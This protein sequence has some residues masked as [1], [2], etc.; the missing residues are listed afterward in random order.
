MIPD[1]FASGLTGV[2]QA[3]AGLKA[4]AAE[5]FTVTDSGGQALIDAMNDLHDEITDAISHSDVLGQE[6]PLGQTPAAQVY[7]PFLATIA[8]DPHQGMIP[9]LR[10][11]LKDL[12][13][14]RDSIQK[15]ME[16]YKGTDQ[17]SKQGLNKAGGTTYSV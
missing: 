10:K 13:D 15:S 5:G 16:S 6:P 11:L 4:A 2:S 7:K 3:V 12:T 14:A 9:A 8:T 17:G 1:N